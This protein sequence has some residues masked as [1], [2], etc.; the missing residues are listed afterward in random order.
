MLQPNPCGMTDSPDTS[1]PS[2]E[3]AP[4]SLPRPLRLQ[5]WW[6][7]VVRLLILGTSISVGWM[8]GLLVAQVWPSGHPNPPLQERVMRQTSQT[9]RKVHQLPQWWQGSEA[10][11][12]ASA[13]PASEV[14]TPSS[15]ET[16]SS[17]ASTPA[18]SLLEQEVTA[19]QQNLVNL[20]NQLVNLEQQAGQPGTGTLEDRLQQLAAA[21]ASD[22]ALETGTPTATVPP[23]DSEGN[24]ESIP[25]TD[26][27]SD[28][29]TEAPTEPTNDGLGRHAG[30]P[31]REPPFPLVS[32]R[33]SLPSALLFAPESSLLTPTG[34]QLLD[35]IVPDLRRF[36]AVTFL[37]G[38]HTDGDLS[39][40]D[41][42]QLTFQQALAVQTYLTAQLEDT[43]GRWL[44]VGYGKTRPLAVGETPGAEARNQRLEIG[45]LRP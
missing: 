15:E 34:K 45:I 17:E 28:T 29:G 2:S 11:M 13:P 3:V 10:A 1:R 24:P 6:T 5:G 40:E 18:V 25:D 19:L 7:L 32:D 35:A 37:V 36:G 14:T 26:T 8:A 16:G 20:E 42:R 39:A 21:A 12:E 22:A 9:L 38:S 41:T 23:T 31:F 43:N 27:A 44:A 33:I 4:P 30:T